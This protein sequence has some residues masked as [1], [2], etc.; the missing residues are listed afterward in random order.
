MIR[1]TEQTLYRLDNLNAEQQRISYQM[2]TGKE[3][4]QGSDDSG[5]YAR[6]IYV[7]D[8][9]S[10][11][12][13]L[14]VQIERTTA[15]NNVADSNLGEAKDLVSYI[16]AEV[17]KALTAT[18]S[19]EGRL[20]IADNL[21]GV[22]ENLLTLANGKVEG[23]Y[24]F[25]GS[26]T[27]IPAFEKDDATGKV[28]Y[29]GNT[30]LRKI[31]VE[32]GTYRERGITGL[33]TFFYSSSTAY[34]DDDL[35]FS[36]DDRIFD[37]DGN[38][39][40]LSGTDIVQ[41]DEDGNAISGTEKAVTD[42]GATPPTYTVN[43]GSDDGTKFEAKTNIFDTLDAIVN[44]LK[45]VD[46]S[47]NPVSDDVAKAELQTGLDE[48]TEAYDGMNL[49]HAKLGGRNKVFEMSYESISAKLTQYDILSQEIGAADLTKVAVEA[50]ALELTY[51][52]LYS[53]INKMN[54]LSLVNFIK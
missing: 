48:I 34:K 37:Q 50:K 32:D 51:T 20:A 31:A 24:L 17:I 10:V 13:G 2:S 15:Q 6:E 22:K 49:G 5:L 39:W 7:D 28:T 8:K 25:S 41:L 29:T 21:E 52:A 43:V 12:T 42:D 54:D 53:T 38:E 4:Q 30:E 40:Q 36:A 9:I 33:D 11:Y 27:S 3:L 46:S 47:G 45:K 35:T 1:S 16:K 19:D 26:D 23:E 18:T 44:S 14:K